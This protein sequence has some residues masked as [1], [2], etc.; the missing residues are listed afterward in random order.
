[1]NG[2]GDAEG[3]RRNVSHGRATDRH[4]GG[5]LWGARAVNRRE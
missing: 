4:S 3:V 1:M 5:T 2:G